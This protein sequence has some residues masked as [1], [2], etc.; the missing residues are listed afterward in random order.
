MGTLVGTL[1]AP[2]GSTGPARGTLEAGP[3]ATLE[4][5]DGVEVLEEEGVVDVLVETSPA[6]VCWA[7]APT[8]EEEEEEEEG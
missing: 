1:E 3:A 5:D 2:P 7:S 6:P 8:S 4:G